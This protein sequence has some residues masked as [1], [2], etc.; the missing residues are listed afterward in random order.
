[1][2]CTTPGR[3][4]RVEDG[5]HRGRERRQAVGRGQRPVGRREVGAEEQVA[6]HHPQTRRA[7]RYGAG[8]LPC[9]AAHDRIART[10][11]RPL[12]RS[13]TTRRP[14]WRAVAA[15][16][17]VAAVTLVTALIATSAAGVP[18]RDPG[19]VS[20][21]AL[22]RARPRS[23]RCWSG[24]GHRVPRRPRALDAGAGAGGRGSALVSFYVTYLAYRNLKSV[25]PL[26]RPD[27]LFDGRL[28]DL[29]R[30]LFAGQ[31]PRR[32]CCT[33]CSAAGVSA[34]ALSGVYELFFVFIP[35]ALAF[36][37]VVLAGPARRAVPHHRARAQLGA[38]RRRATS[39][40]RRS[41]R[42]T[43]TPAQFAHLPSPASAACRRPCSSSGP[44]SCATRRPRGAAQSIGAFASLHVSIFFTAALATHLL[45][46]AALCEDRGVGP[47]RPAP[48]LATIYF[49]WHYVLDDV[50]GLAIAVDGARPRPGAHRDRPAHRR[51]S[52]CR[53]RAEL[54]MASRTL[55][56]PGRETRRR[57][58]AAR[59]R[60]ASTPPP[61]RR[62]VL[63]GPIVA[64]FTLIVGLF[65]T[66]AARRAAAR[67][68]P[69]RRALPRAGRL[70]R[71][72]CSS[73]STSRSARAP[74]G[75]APAVARGDAAGP[76]RA[77]DAGAVRSRP[78]PRC[79]AS[80]SA[81]W[82]TGT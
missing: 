1:M 12:L 65:A 26:L 70:R 35:L 41:A 56:E 32:R 61:R 72:R 51:G 28:G 50:A 33:A 60:T 53:R 31:R 77:L 62:S 54:T 36:A 63:A 55:L 17:L 66:D 7:H 11:P 16:P 24:G 46:L 22:H 23:S 75:H 4:A 27:E 78:A 81:T 82:P 18:L 6:G 67:P 73:G 40:C 52:R 45:G 64:A 47:V 80:T 19:G 34:H 3:L 48:S 37:L 13:R 5:R 10:R 15:G 9:C 71:R 39:C 2:R 76:A 69:R 29:D 79:S 59:R 14:P 49:G 21:R 68:R 25:V 43:P 30:S 38:G 44:S 8:W 42:S 58:E 20:R 57:A 74:H